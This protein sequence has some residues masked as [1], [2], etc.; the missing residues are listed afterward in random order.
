MAFFPIPKSFILKNKKSNGRNTDGRITVFHRG[1]G[2]R[3]RL[4][5]ISFFSFKKKYFP[6]F[7]F[8]QLMDDLENL[9]LIFL[10][11]VKDSSRQASLGLVQENQ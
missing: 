10:K 11:K 5:L 9:A 8:L 7:F 1:G 6:F 3:K 2:N 4:R